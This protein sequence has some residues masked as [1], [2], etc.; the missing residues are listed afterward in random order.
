MKQ[1]VETL[2]KKRENAA[3]T[4]HDLNVLDCVN[5]KC[6]PCQRDS[7]IAAM[8][9]PAADR[10]KHGWPALWLTDGKRAPSLAFFDV[11]NA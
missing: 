10:I 7:G 6:L 8:C 1:I 2:E 5:T 9:Q 3:F 4:Y 11:S